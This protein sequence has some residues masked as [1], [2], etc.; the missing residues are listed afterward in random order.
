LRAPREAVLDVGAL[1]DMLM[2]DGR[3]GSALDASSRGASSGARFGQSST[4]M[5]ALGTIEEVGMARN[6][7]PGAVIPQEPI[8][9]KKQT[10]A[11]PLSYIG[12]TRRATAWVRKVGTNWWKFSLATF[13]LIIWLS[14]IWAFV[15]VWYL[16]VFGIFGIFTFPYRFM[17]RA[18]RKELALQSQQ[19]AT[20]QAMVVQQQQT[21][22]EQQ[23]A[24]ANEQ[25]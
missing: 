7:P 8:G 1:V 25:Q 20:M 6:A 21:L 14:L 2:P 15:T 12:S 5:V 23:K 9:L 3:R 10:F 11:S 16:I 18:Q 24:S 19:L 17:R 4:T 13:A 22:A